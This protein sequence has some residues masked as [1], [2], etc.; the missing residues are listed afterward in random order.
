MS[1]RRSDTT[2]QQD[3]GA[4]ERSRPRLFLYPGGH[5]GRCPGR[6]YWC[7]IPRYAQARRRQT[8]QNRARIDARSAP[9]QSHA[10]RAPA[11]FS[12]IDFLFFLTSGLDDYI[13][14]LQGVIIKGTRDNSA[15]SIP[16]AKQA[17]TQDKAKNQTRQRSKRTPGIRGGECKRAAAVLRPP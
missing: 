7:Q 13:K 2:A 15:S 3:G 16:P 17:R 12:F 6:A 5:D 11:L 4:G 10:P 1:A 14:E 8:H 9:P